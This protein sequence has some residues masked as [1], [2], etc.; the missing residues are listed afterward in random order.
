MMTK[1][2]LSMGARKKT[3]SAT[4]KR[5]RLPKKVQTRQDKLFKLISPRKDKVQHQLNESIQ[6]L[7]RMK[8]AEEPCLLQQTC[9]KRV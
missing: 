5:T 4:T 8:I 1:M 7:M 2:Q 9:L 3:Y 6:E